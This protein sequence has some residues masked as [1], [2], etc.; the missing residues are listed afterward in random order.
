[1]FLIE[2]FDQPEGDSYADN[3]ATPNATQNKRPQT[4]T[5]EHIVKVKDGYRIVS[6]KTGKNL[7]TYPTRAGAEKRERQVQYFKHMDENV[8]HR[9][10]KYEIKSTK[11][12]GRL[13]F[14]G[15]K[16][17]FTGSAIK[18]AID[19]LTRTNRPVEVSTIGYDSELK[20]FVVVNAVVINPGENVKSAVEGLKNTEVS[21]D[22]WSNPGGEG[23]AWHNGS[24]DQWYDGQDQWHSETNEDFAVTNMAQTNEDNHVSDVIT[25]KQLINAARV[26]SN[27]AYDYHNFINH[28]RKKYGTEYSTNVH[29]SASKLS[30]KAN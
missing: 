8:D 2:F 29:Q 23:N 16:T 27:K 11:E 10:L 24:D 17:D 13:E 22:S 30:K 12:N 14:F 6:K 20:R 3:Q 9:L 5:N 1:M 28:L 19:A 18:R 26:D 4:Q 25:A 7:G 15:T 21:E